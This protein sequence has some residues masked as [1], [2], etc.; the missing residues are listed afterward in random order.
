MSTKKPR[1][2]PGGPV[3]LSERVAKS[4]AA[5]EKRGGVKLPAGWLQPDAAKALKYL[6][7]RG[8]APTRTG[9][10]A[11]SLTEAAERAESHVG[12]RGRKEKA[13]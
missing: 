7:K 10:I 13:K 9:C 1:Q 12:K 3:P 4:R 8:Y 11:R 2:S 5:L 6:H